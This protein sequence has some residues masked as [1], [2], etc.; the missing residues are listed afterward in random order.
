MQAIGAAPTFVTVWAGNNDVL[1]AALSGVALEGVT[2]TPAAQFQQEY[3]TLLGALR[4]NLSTN[5]AYL[6][7]D[8]SGDSTEAVKK[9]E[10]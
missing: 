2:L 10:K 4:Q 1:G 7:L 9:V 6:K 8:L 5:T 3:T